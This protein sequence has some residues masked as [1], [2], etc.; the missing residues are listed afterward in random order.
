M[1]L[2][3]EVEINNKKLTHSPSMAEGKKL[4]AAWGKDTAQWIGKTFVCHIVRYPNK[5]KIEIEPDVIE[6]VKV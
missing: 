3:V 4:V 5:Q 6:V 1:Q 2:N